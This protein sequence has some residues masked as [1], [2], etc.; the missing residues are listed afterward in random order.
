M[1]VARDLSIEF[2]EE[3]MARWE[4]GALARVLARPGGKEAWQETLAEAHELLRPAAVWELVAIREI[5][6]ASV[7]LEAGQ[8]LS[9]GPVSMVVADA[10]DLVVAICTVGEAVSRR[11]KEHQ[12][13]RRLLRGVLLDDLATWAVD[14][15]RQRLCS[16]LREE[17][18]A[19]GRHVS[20]SLSPGESEWPLADQAAIFSVLDASQIGVSLSRSLV[21][22]PLKSLSLIMGWG[23]QPLGRERGTGCDYCT[24]RDRCTYR[25]RRVDP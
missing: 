12:Q 3:A 16:R 10:S 19:A 6:H 4:G 24:M 22:S 11:I 2:D 1:T 9:G 14:I 23:S 21:M 17:A 8:R 5:G 13:A 18:Q 25:C 7:V 15:V 20:V